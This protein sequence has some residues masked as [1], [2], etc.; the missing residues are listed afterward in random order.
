VFNDIVSIIMFNT[1]QKFQFNFDFDWTTPFSILYQFFILALSSVAIGLLFGV[2]SAL[3]F[4]WFRFLCHSS[5][6][7]TL[8]VFLLAMITY[9]ISEALELSGIISML[10]CGI[11]MAHYTWY[12]LSPQGKTISSVTVSVFGSAAEALVFAYIGLCV[13]TYAGN[14]KTGDADE[15]IW[16]LSFI[17]WMTAIIIVGRCTAVGLAHLL[18]GLCSKKKDIEFRELLFVMYGGMIRGAIAF[19]LVLKIPE[20]GGEGAF[21]ERGVVVTTTLA[22]VIITTVLFGSF[23]PVIQKILVPPKDSDTIEKVVV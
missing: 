1:V 21:K 17:L 13:F 9:F 23:M 4:K 10:T 3:V 12:N 8:I 18:F 5:I 20:G 6:T 7:E 15:H 11:T 16:S 14:S 22:V 19:G 2:I